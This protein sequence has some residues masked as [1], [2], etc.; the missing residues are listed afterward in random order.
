V[1]SEPRLEYR[2]EQ[3][4][5]AMRTKVSMAEIPVALPPLIPEV[6]TWL[7]HRAADPAGAPFFRY[8]DMD[9]EHRLLVEV[10]VPVASALPEDD[11][12]VTGIFPAGRYLVQT[13]TGPYDGLRAAWAALEDWK[14]VRGIQEAS[15]EGENGVRWGTRTEF[16]LTDPV[17]EMDPAKWRTDLVLL[18][19]GDADAS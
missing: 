12:I 16:Y 3:P 14:Q 8:L 17:K 5:I 7:S 4:Y 9:S 10:G 18:V 2:K 19:R 15:T 11:R 13:H 1:N 6:L